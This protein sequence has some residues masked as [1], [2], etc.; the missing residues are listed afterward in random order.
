MP[1]LGDILGAARRNAA[2]FAVWVQRANPDLAAQVDTAAGAGGM[3]SSA[4]V[5][6]AISD[7]SREASSDDW[8]ELVSMLRDASD[9][10]MTCLATMI[11]WQIGRDAAGTCCVSQLQGEGA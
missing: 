5:R 10:G 3:T 7:Y 11:R 1:T 2:G 6:R 4:F 8:T 9:P